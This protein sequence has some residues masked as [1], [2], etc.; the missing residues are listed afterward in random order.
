[1]TP[2]TFPNGSTTA[3]V[4]N[5]LSPRGVIGWY[6]LAPIDSSRWKVAAI[7]STCQYMTA[8]PGSAAAAGGAQRRSTSPSS[9]SES[10]MRNSA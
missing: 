1:M 6:S 10:P 8:P 7:S 2:S 5:P 3:A 9:S 4:T